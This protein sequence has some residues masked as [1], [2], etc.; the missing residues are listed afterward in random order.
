M[1]RQSERSVDAYRKEGLFNKEGQAWVDKT[2]R[3]PV[4]DGWAVDGPFGWSWEGTV[5][6]AV[7]EQLGAL[8]AD[9]ACLG[10]GHSPVVLEVADVK[11]NWLHS[12]TASRFTPGGAWVRVAGVGRLDALDEAFDATRPERRPTE[13]GDRHESVKAPRTVPPA[14]G[15]L[16]MRRYVSPLRP[17]SSAPWSHAIL[18]SLDRIAPH[19]DNGKNAPSNGEP[20]AIPVVHRVSWAVAL[21]RALAKRVGEEAPPL[22][23]GRY[24]GPHQPANRIAIQVL[25]PA[26]VALS[27]ADSSADGS[28]A[29]AIMIPRDAA[30]DDITVLHRALT[31]FRTLVSRRGRAEVTVHPDAV[32]CDEFWRPPAEGCA[33]LWS[34]AGAVVPEG[35][36]GREGSSL[37]DAVLLSLGYVLRDV[38]PEAAGLTRRERVAFLRSKGLAAAATRRLMVDVSDFV[39]KVPDGMVPQAC[40]TLIDLGGSRGPDSRTSDESA[41]VLPVGALLAIGQSRHLGGGL[42]LPVDVPVDAAQMLMG[43]DR[44]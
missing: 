8:C 37:D 36:R 27:G 25:D 10:E 31:G 30:N 3:R 42:L 13:K 44:V 29:I 7:R 38:F 26:A 11:P 33:R 18:L 1:R 21:H 9:V 23:T 28:T 41:P 35:R 19:P 17:L 39:H 16:E 14:S 22:I 24:A 5:P 34:P 2:S 40:T 20:A 4:S 15:G 32:P 6:S 12:P 43:A